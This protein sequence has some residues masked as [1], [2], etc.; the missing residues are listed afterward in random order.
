MAT[1]EDAQLILKLYELRRDPVMREARD[2]VAFKFF[3]ESAQDIKDL[4]FDK[5][6]PVH[7][8][9][10]RQVTTYWDMAAALVNHGTLDEALFFDTNTECFAVFAKLEPFLPELRDMFGPWY[11][12]NL[13][14]LIRRYPNYSERLASLRTRLKLYGEAYKSRKTRGFHP[15][16]GSDE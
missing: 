14:K 4:L 10:W 12:V 3:P 2:F 6:N 11:M 7:G 8:A 5:R 1:H 13:E 15:E 9:Y 16:S